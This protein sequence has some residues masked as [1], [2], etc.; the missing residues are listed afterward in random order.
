MGQA[1]TNQ[2]LTNATATEP[3][4]PTRVLWALTS[5]GLGG[6]PE[7]LLRVLPLMGP[8]GVEV[9]VAGA[10]QGVLFPELEAIAGGSVL[11]DLSR[12]SLGSLRRLLGYCRQRD[13]EVVHTFGKGAGLTGRIAALL[14]RRAAV[15]SFRGY[16][17]LRFA[18][19][20]EPVYRGLEGWLGRRSHRLVA[21]SP[22]E[23]ETIAKTGIVPNE[24]IEVIPNGIDLETIRA[25]ALSP[26]EARRQLGLPPSGLIVGTLARPDPVKNLGEFVEIAR[27]VRLQRP[28]VTFAVVGVGEGQ[29]G[30]LHEAEIRWIPPQAHACRVLRAFDVY[31]STSLSEGLPNA[32]LEATSLGIPVV[33]SDVQGNRD[34][35]EVD[36]TGWLY[37]LGV[38]AEACRRIVE[39]EAGQ[40]VDPECAESFL[41]RYSL[42]TQAAALTRLYRSAAAGPRKATSRP[43]SRTTSDR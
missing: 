6:A 23:A 20:R 7:Q 22:S 25:Q 10:R 31:L 38:P 21:V 13:I 27:L 17:S 29:E 34:A 30:T 43:T 11:A 39:I 12:V 14:G 18:G 15:H 4:R 42:P 2:S 40:P 26:G 35:V 37:P 5:T 33:L 24:K 36:R 41:S 9:H 1:V 19:W 3:Q 8:C 28:D 16:S 32:P